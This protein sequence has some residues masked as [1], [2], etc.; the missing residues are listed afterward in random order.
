M[1]TQLKQKKNTPS[2]FEVSL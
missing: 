1:K 2:C